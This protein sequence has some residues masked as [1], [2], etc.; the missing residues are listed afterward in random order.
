MSN[1]GIIADDFDWEN[2]TWDVIDKFFKQDDILINHHLTSFNNFM[3]KDLQSIVREKEFSTVKIYNKDKY[4]EEK[5]LYREI[6]EI[7]FGKIHI[8]KPVLYDKPNKYMYPAEA[9]LRKLTYS[10]NVYLD[11]HHRTINIK[12]N[13]EKVIENHPTLEKYPCSK[14]PIMVGSKFCVLNEQSN[15]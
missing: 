11:I 3:E 12:E 4:D 9:R 13:G 14:L 6:Y 2:N 8:S 7:E 10:A 15:L 1:K 5:E